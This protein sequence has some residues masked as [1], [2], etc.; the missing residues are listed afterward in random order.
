MKNNLSYNNLIAYNIIIILCVALSVLHL[1]NDNWLSLAT[2]LIF[3][4]TTL[5]L[6][7][8]KRRWLIL[9][10]LLILLIGATVVLNA[11]AFS[12][13]KEMP[14][15]MQ[16]MQMMTAA[17]IIQNLVLTIY[18]FACSVLLWREKRLIIRVIGWGICLYFA[19]RLLPATWFTLQLIASSVG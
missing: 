13:S 12:L 7:K 1:T 6:T 19:I 4:I 14:T 15:A 10:G 2:Y 5:I 11:V 17:T 9:S 16:S 18:L 3:F 8:T